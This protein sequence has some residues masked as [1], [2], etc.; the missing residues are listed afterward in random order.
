MTME[1]DNDVV[2]NSDTDRAQT[3]NTVKKGYNYLLLIYWFLHSTV[4]L[5]TYDVKGTEPGTEG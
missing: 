5:T 3:E 2:V 1:L 4:F